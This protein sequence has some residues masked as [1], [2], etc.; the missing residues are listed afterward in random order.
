MHVYFFC[1]PI[2][3]IILKLLDLISSS[4]NRV[5]EYSAHPCT[6]VYA[7]TYSDKFHKLWSAN[8]PDA[9][10]NDNLEHFLDEKCM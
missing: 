1:E 4:S 2:F 5:F 8:T 9:T 7:I 10:E 3:Q 6:L